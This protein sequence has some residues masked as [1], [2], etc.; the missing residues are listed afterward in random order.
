MQFIKE[1]PPFC[2]LITQIFGLYQNQPN[3]FNGSTT[4]PFDIET[5][6]NVEL[7]IYNILG[8]K[9]KTLLNKNC[10]AGHYDITWNGTNNYGNQV[11]SG[12]YLYKIVN[13]SNTKIKKMV[14][15]K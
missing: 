10:N 6:S 7:V 13:G 15:V 12:I 1:C 14:Y 8:Q 4:I 2:A 9:V 11:S 3:P 5:E